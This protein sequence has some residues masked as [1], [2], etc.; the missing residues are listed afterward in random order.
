M[1]LVLDASMTLAWHIERADPG[2]KILA[3][4]AL[5][6]VRSHGALVPALWYSEVANGV[7]VAGEYLPSSRG[8]FFRQ[9]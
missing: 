4:Q 7:L 2:E 6:A 5:Q 1:K 8:W 9:T 3:R